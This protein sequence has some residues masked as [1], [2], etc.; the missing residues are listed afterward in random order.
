LLLA[1]SQTF[2]KEDQSR[3]APPTRKAIDPPQWV[4]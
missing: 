1:S 2:M 3:S 4:E